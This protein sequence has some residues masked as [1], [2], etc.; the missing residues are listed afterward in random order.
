MFSISRDPHFGKGEDGEILYTP[1]VRHRPERDRK[2]LRC[3][4]ISSTC[5]GQER[6]LEFRELGLMAGA[7]WERRNPGRSAENGKIEGI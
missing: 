3:G 7:G 5:A 6:V 4:Q 1:G 2:N